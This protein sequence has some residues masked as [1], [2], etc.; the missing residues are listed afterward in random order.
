MCGRLNVTDNPAVID[1]LDLL[2]V[3]LGLESLVSKGLLRQGRFIRATEQ[4]SL[5]RQ[6]EGRAQLTVATWWLLLEPTADGFK[7][8]PYT[9]FN[10]RS[11]KLMVRGSAGFQAFQSQRCIIPVSG[12]GETEGSGKTARYTDFF[13]EQALPL[14]G[15]YRRWVHH[16]TGEERLSCSVIT[17][18]PH[19]KLR[20][21]HSKA[22]PLILPRDVCQ[23]WLD[24]T[25]PLGELTPLL[26]PWLPVGLHAQAID[27]PA[28]HQPIGQLDWL[29][30]DEALVA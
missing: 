25:T 29:A 8:S 6:Q 30:A 26:A 23:R 1:L 27:K 20:P 14:G 17:L 7:P 28:S 24:P 10:T 11:D 19:P 5:V 15:L 3:P 12:F 4:V 22:M 2:G 21:Y 9:S 16:G 18:P 13:G